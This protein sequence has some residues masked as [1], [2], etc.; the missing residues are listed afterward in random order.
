MDGMFMGTNS[1]I[2]LDLWD[3]DSIEILR[4]PQ[5]TLFGRNTIGG[6]VSVKRQ[7][8]TGEFG[9]KAE[10]D[11]GRYDREDFKAALNFPI[12]PGKAAGKQEVFDFWMWAYD[13]VLVK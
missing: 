12:V 4:G 1:G 3:I 9:F 5:G 7:K 6:V 13:S 8:P 10:A 11:I 2:N